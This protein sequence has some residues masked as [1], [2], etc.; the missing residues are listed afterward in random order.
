[1][2][3]PPPT[4]SVPPRW[5][6]LALALL[7]AGAL[8]LRPCADAATPPGAPIP[9]LVGTFT[10]TGSKGVYALTLDPA[11]GSLSTPVVAAVTPDPAFLAI[12]RDGRRLYV[13]N[14]HTDTV[15]AWAVGPGLRLDPLGGQPSGGD[16][17]AHIV[18]DPSER[19]LVGANYLGPSVCTFAVLPD[20]RLGPRTSLIVHKGPAGPNKERQAAA[21]PHAALFTPDGAHVL[22]FDLGLDRVY[23]YRTDVAA[24]TLAPAPVPFVSLPPGVG[25]RHGILS[26]DGRFLYVVNEMGGSVCVLAMDPD[27]AGAHLVQTAGIAPR[28]FRGTNTSAEIALSPDGRF[29]YASNRGPDTIAVLARNPADGRVSL[30]GQVPCGGS[31]PRCFALSPDGRWLVCANQKGNSLTVFSI[32]P[33][34]GVPVPTGHGAS[35]PQPVCVLFTP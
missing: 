21:H 20:G 29:L 5:R 11:S 17:T 25:P 32:D 34:G 35:I 14:E 27:G 33:A 28:D 6:L 23:F 18:L 22:V 1:M 3:T 31:F 19:M 2:P 10:D 9:I 26:A 30:V 7:A 8:A 24:A 15:S 4:P 13:A 12:T 16:N